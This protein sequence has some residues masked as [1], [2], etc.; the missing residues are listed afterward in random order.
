MPVNRSKGNAVI[1]MMGR[2]GGVVGFTLSLIAE[3]ITLQGSF[4]TVSILMIVSLL[5]LFWN[6]NET[7][8]YSYKQI[9]EYEMK[10]G[11][12]LK[13]EKKKPGLIESL[14]DI[15][16]EENKSI[17]YCKVNDTLHR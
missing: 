5:L 17:L 6:V 15:Q 8:S 14:K 11:K 2:L 16:R 3:V 7:D 10:E 13:E 9:I 12:K 1:N 4:I